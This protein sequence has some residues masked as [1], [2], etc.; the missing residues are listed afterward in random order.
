MVDHVENIYVQQV[1]ELRI[2]VRETNHCTT[3]DYIMTKHDQES[4]MR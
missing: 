1:I 4:N 2:Q 3:D